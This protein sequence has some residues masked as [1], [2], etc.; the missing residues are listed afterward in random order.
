M[1]QDEMNGLQRVAAALTFGKPDRVPGAPCLRC[2][3]PF[4]R[5]ELWRMVAVAQ[6]SIAMVQ[7]HVDAL[8]FIGHDGVVMLVDL[9]VEVCIRC[10]VKFLK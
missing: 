3:A 5:P 4:F 6:M 1:A 7:G 9:T 10:E 2:V 8:D